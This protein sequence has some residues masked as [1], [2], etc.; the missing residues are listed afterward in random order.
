MP[1]PTVHAGSKRKARRKAADER[2]V[3][4]FTANL[5]RLRDLAGKLTSVYEL[6]AM[7]RREVADDVVRAEIRK[8]VI[9]FM[10]GDALN[11]S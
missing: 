2:R 6:D 10:T 5:T 8:L 11:V 7:L 3:R 9:P 1:R 4:R